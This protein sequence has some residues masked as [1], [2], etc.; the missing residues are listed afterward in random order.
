MSEI[1]IETTT[2][3]TDLYR[4]VWQLREDVLRI[5]LG[6]SLKNEDLSMDKE[7]VIYTA[8]SDGKVIGCL[9][10]HTISDTVM[11]FRQMAVHPTVQSSGVGRLL[12]N[13]AE[14]DIAARGYT[15]AILHARQVAIGFYEKLGYTITS[16]MFTE[17][18][19]PHVIMKKMLQ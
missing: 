13:K 12:M 18:G 2:V 19:I 10:L 4:Q 9:M 8:T 3:D 6:H 14:A 15:T 7:D 16:S 17:V 1:L 5:P 11:K